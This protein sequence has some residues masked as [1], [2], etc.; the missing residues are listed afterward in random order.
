MELASNAYLKFNPINVVSELAENVMIDTTHNTQLSAIDRQANDDFNEHFIT[1]RG[2]VGN[3]KVTPDL[4]KVED[5]GDASSFMVVWLKN[6][7][8]LIHLTQIVD[9]SEYSVL[10]V[11]CGNGVS[12]LYFF[13]KYDFREF[14]GFDF[15]S[16]LIEFAKINCLKYEDKNVNFFVEDARY[17]R[18][19][20]KPLCLFMFN[21]FGLNTLKAFIDNNIQVLRD[22][23]SLLLYAN[24]IQLT[25]LQPYAKCLGRD[26]K[27]NLSAWKF[28]I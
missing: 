20:N 9:F 8:R 14:L 28:G 5:K 23:K 19:P 6:I 12:T 21:P 2:F 24:D 27:Y 7:D 13:E 18:L 10:D 11:G 1:A 16:R 26:V 15:D 17:Y 22:N 25:V 3:D 4:F